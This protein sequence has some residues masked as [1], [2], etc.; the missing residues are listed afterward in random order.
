MAGRVFRIEGLRP[1]TLWNPFWS[2]SPIF[3]EKLELFS[4]PAE[5]ENL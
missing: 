5:F 2:R 4:K 3:V 1:L